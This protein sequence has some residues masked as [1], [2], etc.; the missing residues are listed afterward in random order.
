MTATITTLAEKKVIGIPMEMSYADYKARELWQRFMPK[1]N[2]VQNR[3]GAD[4]FSIEVFSTSYWDQFN[5]TATFQKWAAVTVPHFDTIP[6][7]M[8]SLVI[9]AG[10]YAV[11]IYKGDETGAPA[12]FKAI[13]TSWL[14]SSI[15]ILDD[16]P[17]F[18]I[19]GDKYKRGDT[20]SEEEVWIP[21]QL[22]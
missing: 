11:F 3:V 10:L 7:G 17:H 21:I 1:R 12:F 22:K 20:N 9:P 6:A 18:E 5:P 14:P 4:Y 19:L 2:E 13:F 8:Q 15:Y 16:R